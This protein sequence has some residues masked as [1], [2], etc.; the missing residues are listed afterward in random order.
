MKNVKLFAVTTWL[1]WGLR[2]FLLRGGKG[3][4]KED[5]WVKAD[6]FLSDYVKVGS[7]DTTLPHAK[8]TMPTSWVPP[9]GDVF[10]LNVDAALDKFNRRIGIGIVVRDSCGELI[11]AAISSFKYIV[12]VELAETKA[13][14]EGI[15]LALNR[16]LLSLCVESDTLNVVSLCCGAFRVRYDL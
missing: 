15:Q 14:C 7:C 2:N 12:D 5:L 16:G 4:L 11:L 10:K 1:A 8:K 3:C 9:Q 6:M 13:I